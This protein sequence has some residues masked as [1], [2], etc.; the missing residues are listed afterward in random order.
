MK[1]NG[2]ALDVPLISIRY[3]R[4]FLRFTQKHGISGTIV[5]KE[6]RIDPALLDNP[7]AFLTMRQLLTMLRH[8]DALLKDDTASFRFGQELDLQGH[9]LLG[10]ALLRQQDYRKLVNMVV[11]YLRVSLP[12]M[13]MEIHCTGEDISIRLHD[14]WDLGELRPFVT[15]IYMG[16]IH[17]LASLV[18]RR[19]TFEYD[20]PCPAKASSFQHLGEGIEMKFNCEHNRL[21]LPLSGRQARDDDATVAN[22]LATARSQ[23]QAQGD[24]S[25]KVVIQV[26]HE[27][28]NAPGRDS[29]LERVAAKLGMSPRS[30]RRHLSLSGFAFSGLRNE[31]REMFATRYLV[32]TDM[33]LEK[34]AEYLGYSDQASF[35]KAYRG[36]TGHTPG[37]VRRNA[38][39]PPPSWDSAEEE[40]QNVPDGETP[41]QPGH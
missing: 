32:D 16:S 33:A 4:R 11:Q 35:S 8:A 23:E 28:R 18:C 19:F 37:E 1:N 2:M 9:G 31:I 6:A 25:L 30:V 12:I 15:N 38:K 36:W 26:R 14:S 40:H 13:D 39:V 41:P 3:A 34:I 24:E 21:L 7:D 22:Y 29:T 27:I 10:F 20:F 5:L 17:A